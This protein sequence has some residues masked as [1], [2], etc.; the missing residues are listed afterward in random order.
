MC[1]IHL[2]QKF[3]S[4]SDD[5]Q[6]GDDADHQEDRD[7]EDCKP[8]PD[9]ADNEISDEIEEPA[10]RDAVSMFGEEPPASDMLEI[11]DPGAFIEKLGQDGDMYRSYLLDAVI[12]TNG[13]GDLVRVT[14]A[15]S[16]AKVFL[17]TDQAKELIR[18]A[19]LLSKIVTSPPQV[20][21]VQ[22]EPKGD[23]QT[24]SFLF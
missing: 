6:E 14:V 24:E 10:P 21:I 20:E 17:N 11:P 16:F 3:L 9:D 13:A 15:N 1:F 8:E 19:A 7:Q 4:L 2:F 12:E 18:K 23:T 22:S 5:P